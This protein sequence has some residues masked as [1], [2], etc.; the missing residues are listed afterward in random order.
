[1][2]PG[3][4]YT[5]LLPRDDPFS[6]RP[7][8]LFEG[9]KWQTQDRLTVTAQTAFVDRAP[10][11]AGYIRL[12]EGINRGPQTADD[13]QLR[14]PGDLRAVA[15]RR[16]H[17]ALDFVAGHPVR[18]GRDRGAQY[19]LCRFDWPSVSDVFQPDGRP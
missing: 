18:H 9:R 5:Q 11:L 1:M 16:K 15:A 10:K 3:G 8:H 13:R 12:P 6:N 14:D 19:L 7:D 2:R 4:K 17:F